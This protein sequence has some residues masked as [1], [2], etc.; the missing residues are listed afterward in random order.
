MKQKLTPEELKRNLHYD[1]ETGIWT[2]LIR[3]ANTVKIGDIAGGINKEPSQGYRYIGV[4][5]GLYKSS[6][7]AFLYM[8]GYFPE[9]DV[10]HINRVRHDDRWINLREISHQCNLRNSKIPDN[11]TSS[12]KGVSWHKAG[13]KWMGH[14]TV[15]NKLKY[16]GL[17][18]SFLNAVCARLAAE[19]CLN[20]HGC[21]SNSPAFQYVQKR[22]I[23]CQK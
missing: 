14:I 9:N 8:L 16:L 1:P 19:Q 12:I 2:R 18:K 22:I 3:S 7:L 11:N 17:Y 21:D 23:R 15:N 6:R 20:W 4:A 10:D 13:K 5:G